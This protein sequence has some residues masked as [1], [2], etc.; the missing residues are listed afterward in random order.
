MDSEVFE[1]FVNRNF[2]G[3][4]RFSLEGAETLI[5]LLDQT[6]ESAAEKGVEEIVMGMSHRGRLNAIVNLFSTP[7]RELFRRF[8]QLEKQEDSEPAGDVRFHTGVQCRRSSSSRRE[9]LLSLW[10]QPEPLGLRRIC[11]AGKGEGATGLPH[12]VCPAW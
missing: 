3:S 7:A 10:F 12:G 11:C 6:I 9:L 1:V 8:E 5:L 2:R 4:K